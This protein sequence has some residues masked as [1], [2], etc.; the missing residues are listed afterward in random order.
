MPLPATRRGRPYLAHGGSERATHVAEEFGLPR[1]ISSQGGAVDASR[2]EPLD[3][4]MVVD[5]SDDEL[6]ARAAS[7]VDENTWCRVARRGASSSRTSCIASMPAIKCF[8]AACRA[9]RSRRRFSS[10]SRLVQESVRGDR[11]P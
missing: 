8:D 9:T 6:L 11:G 2:T 1:S 4:L 5:Q 3:E 10:R 7:A